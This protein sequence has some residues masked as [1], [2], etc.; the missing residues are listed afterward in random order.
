MPIN[1]KRV[2]TIFLLAA[3]HDDPVDRASILERECAADLEL[4]RRVG[5]LL[6]AHDEF[7]GFLNDPVVVAANPVRRK[8]LLSDY[9]WPLRKRK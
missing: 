8:P 1:P 5:A 6:R 2:Q 3:D 4:R 9:F 7:N